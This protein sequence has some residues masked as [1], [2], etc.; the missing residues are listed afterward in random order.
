MKKHCRRDGPPRAIVQAAD[1]P[2]HGCVVHLL[3]FQ[4]KQLIRC[5]LPKKQRPFATAKKT[6][7][8]LLSTSDLF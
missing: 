7:V 3:S 6:D 4:T 5:R 1:D 8:R 2:W